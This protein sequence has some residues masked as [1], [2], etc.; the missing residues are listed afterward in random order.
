M[1]GFTMATSSIKSVVAKYRM[2]AAGTAKP[3]GTGWKKVE[4]GKDSHGGMRRKKKSG[5]YE[6][7]YP[8]KKHAEAASKHHTQIT[9]KSIDKANAAA[10]KYNDLGQEGDSDLFDKHDDK[11]KHHDDVAH[12]AAKFAGI[13]LPHGKVQYQRGQEDDPNQQLPYLGRSF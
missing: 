4:G 8:S 1:K 6:Y 5:G 2:S 3:P 13:K 7:W 10:D 9:N 11:A 12:G